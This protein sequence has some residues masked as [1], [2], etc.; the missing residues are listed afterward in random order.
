MAKT[1]NKFVVEP[2]RYVR[3]K[4]VM[5][6]LWH[7]AQLIPARKCIPVCIELGAIGEAFV[8]TQRG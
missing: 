7:H 6:G 1:S 3:N 4:M 2:L 8:T 5:P